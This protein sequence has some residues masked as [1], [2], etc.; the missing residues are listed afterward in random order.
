MPPPAGGL[1]GAFVSLFGSANE[2]NPLVGPEIRP[3]IARFFPRKEGGSY[4][5]ERWD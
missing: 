1:V 4:R 2:Q 3:V 5:F